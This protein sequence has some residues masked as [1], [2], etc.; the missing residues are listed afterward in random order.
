MQSENSSQ[1]LATGDEI[2][3]CIPTKEPAGFNYT[4]PWGEEGRGP[5]HYIK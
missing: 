1:I 4:Q 5:Q 3:T 2:R